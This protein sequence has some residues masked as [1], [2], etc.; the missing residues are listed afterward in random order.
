MNQT[1]KTIFISAIIAGIAGSAVTLIFIRQ[2]NPVTTPTAKELIKEFYLAENAVHV[3]PHGLRGK[4]DAGDQSYILVDL[5]SPEEYTKEHII[6]AINIYAYKDP[7]TPVYEDK[8]RIV[9][10]FRTLPKDKDIIVYCY[11]TACMTGRKI[12]KLLAENDIFV[13]Q[14]GIGWNEWRHFWTL[15]NHEHEWRTTRAEDYITKGTDPGVPTVRTLPTP[16][17][18]GE[19]GC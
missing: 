11:S 14:L 3:S 6:G 18:I 8:E 7:Y 16:C 15:W 9:E 19:L 4:M 17:G 10:G 2:P 1:L 13:K 5:R 12:G